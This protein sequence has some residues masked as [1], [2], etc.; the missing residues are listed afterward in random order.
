MNYVGGQ[1]CL[2][3]RDSLD[4]ENVLCIVPFSSQ[5]KRGS[6]VVRN[7][8]AEGTDQEVRVYCKGAPDFLLPDTTQVLLADGS[9]AGIEDEGSVPEV[10][11]GGE[12]T[13]INIFNNTIKHF[14]KQAYRTI[15]VT[16]RDMSMEAWEALK[17]ENNGFETDEDRNAIE[18]ELTAIGIFGLQDPLRDTVKGSVEIC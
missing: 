9:T 3:I 4:D 11:G 14:A 1:G 18:K 13:H 17:E 7:P 16:Y 15:I 10:L 6:I 5:R 2:D 12:D 8:D